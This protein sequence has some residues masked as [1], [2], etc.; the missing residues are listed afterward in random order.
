[1]KSIC[2]FSSYFN[3]AKI[4]DYI[5]V[6]LLE[7]SK[8]FSRIIFITNDKEINEESLTFLTQNK[9]ELFLV[10][11][12]GYDFGM[13]HKA[14]AK[15]DVSGYDRLGLINDSCILFGKLD[16]F[17]KWLD[18]EKPDYS[19]LTD[20]YQI[21]YHIQSYFL[22]INKETIPFVIDYFRQNGIIA[23][24]SEVIRVYEVGLSQYLVKMGKNLKAMYHFTKETDS[25]NNAIVWAM[26]LIK[27]GFPMVKKK[28]I[29]R[30][31]KYKYWRSLVARG[32]DPFPEHYIKL[33]AKK[34]NNPEIGKMF[35]E[36]R[37]KKGFLG[38]VSFTTISLLAIL[39][40]IRRKQFY[41]INNY[42]R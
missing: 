36:V 11:N 5:R 24:L 25:N 41:G 39:S 4:P 9:I 32:H 2:F 37:S 28:I 13:W 20:S 8:Y 19:G 21:E 34:I 30:E 23:E 38:E 40:R 31:Y 27:E 3:G 7:L 12:E 29:S 1:M 6:Y 17:F 33:I 26:P 14:L 35:T 42:P 18:K 10:V 15:Y 22:I 16:T